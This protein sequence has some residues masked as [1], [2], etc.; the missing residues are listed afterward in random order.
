MDSR[1]FIRNKN[2]KPPSGYRYPS[3]RELTNELQV[4]SFLNVWYDVPEDSEK[5]SL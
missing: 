1:V 2:K 4:V 3:S 5:K